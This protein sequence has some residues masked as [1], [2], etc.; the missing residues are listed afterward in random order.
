MRKAISIF[1]LGVVSLGAACS[2]DDDSTANETA[3][4]KLA[5]DIAKLLVGACPVTPRD[6][7]VGRE[8]CASALGQSALLR[9]SLRDGFLWGSQKRDANDYSF[10]GTTKFNTFVW[11]KMYLSLLMFPGSYSVEHVGQQTILRMPFLFRNDL[12]MGEYPYPFWH[13][14][15]KWDSWQHA[16]ELLFVIENGSVKGALRSFEADPAK[17]PSVS[18]EWDGQWQWKSGDGDEVEPAVTLYSRLLSPNNP[19]TTKL[20]D[21]YRAMEAEARKHEC[22][23]CH[24]PAN[25][26]G[27][28]QLVFFNY[29]NQAL[30]AR[31]KIAAEVEANKMPPQKGI[32]HDSARRELA[33]LAR[34]FAVVGDDALG[35][36]GEL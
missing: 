12:D 3:N 21:A 8:Q 32:P 36:E 10:R 5:D 11:R 17:Q 26:G 33:E 4:V 16:K 22:F 1:M 23:V 34:A 27:M 30:Y 9:Q 14:K 31:H 18:R 28:N 24:N 15:E 29:P 2:E 20:N 25:G 19:Y 6:D 13:S 7:A 35:F